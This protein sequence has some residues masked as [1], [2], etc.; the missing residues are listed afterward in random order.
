MLQRTLN[1]YHNADAVLRFL[2]RCLLLAPVF[3]L[4]WLVMWVWERR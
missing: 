1:S 4:G 3:A 2:V